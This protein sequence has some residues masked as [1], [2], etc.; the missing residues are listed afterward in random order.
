MSTLSTDSQA[1]IEAFGRKPG[2]TPDHTH[3]LRSVL[4][5]S[6]A[7]IEQFNAAVEQGHVRHIFPLAHSTSGGEY[8]PGARTMYLPLGP[9]SPGS[10]RP[11]EVTFVL[12][13]EL[14]HG[15]NAATTAMAMDEFSDK[16][17]QVARSRSTEHDYTAAIA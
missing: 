9:L 7:L 5:Q 13:H 2:V 8:S 1:I 4:N 3:N 10:L 17:R 16:V 12:G 14:Q 11:G 15:F 6:P